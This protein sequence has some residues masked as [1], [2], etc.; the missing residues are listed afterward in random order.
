MPEHCPSCGAR[1]GTESVCPMCGWYE[2]EADEP[3]D[4]SDLWLLTHSLVLAFD[5]V[6]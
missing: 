4:E 3:L 6:A 5:H 2:D 1:L